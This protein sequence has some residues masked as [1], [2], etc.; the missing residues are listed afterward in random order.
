MNY[1]LR[2]KVVKIC[3]RQ[4]EIVRSLKCYSH[5]E[6][7]FLIDTVYPIDMIDIVMG[8]WEHLVKA[9]VG[10]NLKIQPHFTFYSKQ[11]GAST[12][13]LNWNLFSI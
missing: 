10:N 12:D 4:L 5:F 13:T 9:P 8:S 7:C 3:K 1:V 2:R 6:N 11:C